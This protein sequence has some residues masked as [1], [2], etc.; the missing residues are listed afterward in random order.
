MSENLTISYAPHIRKKRYIS[1]TMRDVLIS[2]SPAALASGYFF[3][4]RSLLVIFTCMVSCA[5]FEI[6]WNK[7]LKKENTITDLSALVTGLLLSMTLPASI[8]LWMAV[9][10]SAFAI[11]IV[12]CFFGGLGQNIVNPA[13]AARAFM[14]SSWP[15]AMTNW[16][17][18][19]LSGATPLAAFK[20]GAIHPAPNLDLFLGINIPGSIGEV[21]ALLLLI[22]GI[23]LV[24]RKVITPV[25]PV[26]YIL[27]VGIFGFLFT[28]S[29]LCKGD[30]LFSIISGGVFLGGIFMATDYTTSPLTAMGQFVYA[31]GAGIIT[32]VIRVYGGYPEG[33]TYAILIMNVV[34]PLIDKVFIPSKFGGKAVKAQ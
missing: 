23:Y 33:V 5:V 6:L 4:F 30:F 27:T 26:T 10:G 20:A 14:L 19:G 22:G 3:G 13:L 11:I 9:A 12:K 16:E 28:K 15:V 24:I 25:I 34:T 8:P 1:T 21:S 29:G 31:L 2:L 18:N 32:G 17:I 7:L